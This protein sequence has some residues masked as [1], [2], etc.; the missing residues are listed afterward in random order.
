[1]MSVPPPI[2]ASFN[3]C[4]GSTKEGTFNSNTAMSVGLPPEKVRP[5]G[6]TVT[7]PMTFGV[8]NLLP[9]RPCRRSSRSVSFLNASASASAVSTPL[10]R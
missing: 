5:F 9:D 4:V 2:Q 7:S 10:G 6:T 1:M 8:M 3:S